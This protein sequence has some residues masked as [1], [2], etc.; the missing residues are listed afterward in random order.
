G[1]LKARRARWLDLRQDD[2]ARL[3]LDQINIRDALAAF[4]AGRS[5][6]GE[7]DLAIETVDLDLPERRADRF[8]FSLAGLLDRRGDSADS[9]VA[10][11]ALG[12][13]GEG[14]AALFPFREEVLGRIGKRCG[15]RHPRREEGQ[16]HGAVDRGSR[17]VDEL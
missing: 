17:L 1:I 15:F 8:R 9:V 3:D 11:E 4:L 7:L 2:F 14:Q 16:M 6:L 12:D 5:R 13:A 10:A